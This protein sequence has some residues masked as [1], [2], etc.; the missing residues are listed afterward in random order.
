MSADTDRDKHL[1][2]L[3]ARLR[4]VQALYQAMHSGQTIPSVIE[5]YLYIRTADP[6]DQD[7]PKPD[8][9]LFKAI[10]NGVAA[11]GADLDALIASHIKKE[12]KDTEFLLKAILMCA[13]WELLANTAVDAPVVI[14]DYLDVAHGFYGKSEIGFLNGVLDALA[15][16]VRQP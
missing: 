3:S 13:A 9:V 15:R 2:T 11:R 16:T 5:E 1:K 7:V 6:E 4:A 10:L 12:N 8:G 14:N